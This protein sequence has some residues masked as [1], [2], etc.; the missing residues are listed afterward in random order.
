MPGETPIDR[1]TALAFAMRLRDL[2]EAAE[3]TQ[4]RAAERARMSRNHYQLLEAGYSDRTKRSPVNPRLSTLLDLAA[5]LGCTVAE[6]VYGLPLG[7]VPVDGAAEQR[8]AVVTAV[9]E[10]SRVRSP[11]PEPTR[12]AGARP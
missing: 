8:G 1:D 9:P 5:A 6:L 12:G 7:G 4:E 3:L 11:E 2:R 10:H